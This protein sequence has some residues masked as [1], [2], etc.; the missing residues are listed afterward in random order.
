MSVQL[1]KEKQV[2][3]LREGRKAV[4]SSKMLDLGWDIAK[5]QLQKDSNSG[6][7]QELSE[8]STPQTA[9]PL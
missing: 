4:P 6:G 5:T 1:Y 2:G 8:T 7:S 9:V 3:K